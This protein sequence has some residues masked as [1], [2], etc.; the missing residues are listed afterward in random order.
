MN[1]RKCIEAIDGVKFPGKSFAEAVLAPIF[2]FQ[3][4]NLYKPFI[5]ISFAHARMLY[6]QSII[7]FD[8]VKKIIKGLKEVEKLDIENRNYDPLYE[9]MFF[10]VENALADLIGVDIAGK[11]HIARSRNDLDICEFRIVLRDKI[12]ALMEWVNK[13]REVLLEFAEDNLDTVMPAYTHTQPAQPTTLAHYI[14]AYYDSLERDFNRLKNLFYI[15]NKSPIGAAAIT[16]TGFPI[17]RE[18]MRELLGFDELIENSY[19]CIAGTDYLTESASV[20]MIL[21][22]NMSKFMKDTLD[23]C[24]KEF[25]VYYLSDPYVQ[26]SSIMPQKRNPSS[27][28]H[29]RPM[30][31]KA[32]GEA[33]N[34]FDV[35]HNTPFGDIVD[36][37]EQL[38]P[39][40]YQSI[41]LTIKI[42]KILYSVFSTIQVN[43][44][45]LFDRAH[46]GFITATELADTLVREKGLSF[47]HSHKVTSELVK[48][49]IKN[50]KQS[51]DI[52]AEVIDE[53]SKRVV[54][55][56][57]ELSQADI[58]KALDPINF[59]NIRNIIGGPAPKEVT[60][61]LNKR[62]KNY[63]EDIQAYN[64]YKQK[65]QNCEN[66]LKILTEELIAGGK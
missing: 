42:L 13:F 1:S 34:I 66:N 35:L 65:L 41:E 55:Y 25:N 51:K 16:T 8:D 15:V 19:D 45:V 52:T 61:M 32:I 57:V 9:D 7:T 10:M 2:E 46:E 28:E 37:E 22:T 23:F 21:N 64:H 26:I 59:V 20:L 29:T 12:I 11:L 48:Y 47:R 17:N 43:K 58:E 24:T 39:H 27:L 54:G 14:L 49:M 44:K 18:R 62:K 31:S 60:R 40:L 6:E 36:T 4:D 30:I 50:Q 33:K 56:N 5:Q 3:R 38:Q 63:E 53:I